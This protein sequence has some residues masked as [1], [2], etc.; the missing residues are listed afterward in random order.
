MIR[1]LL[2]ALGVVALLAGAV[3]GFETA[4]TARAATV[5]VSIA[6]FAFSPGTLNVQVGDTV[7]WTNNDSVPH[8]ATSDSG[9]PS[10]ATGQLDPGANASVTFATPGTYT[11]FCAIH[12]DMRGTIVVAAAAAASPSA[13]GAAS[14][15][16]SPDVPSAGSGIQHGGGASANGWLLA[17]G[18]LVALAA[19]AA[20]LAATRAT[21]T[22]SG[23]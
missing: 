14:P 16:A 1:P 9:S 5:N 4:G 17:G 19:G 23:E 10:F 22:P 15:A 11:Y 7:T 18:V 12:T 21:N 3:A 6:G 20:A 13:T 2:A 8:T